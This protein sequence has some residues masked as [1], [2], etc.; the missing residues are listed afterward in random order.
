MTKAEVRAQ[1]QK[2]ADK[3]AQENKA[4]G[5]P[6]PIPDLYRMAQILLERFDKEFS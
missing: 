6:E 1:L 5:I 4:Q 2:M 3:E